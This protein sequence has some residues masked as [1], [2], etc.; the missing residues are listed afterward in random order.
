MADD[1]KQIM[2]EDLDTIVFDTAEG[3]DFAVFTSSTGT[4]VDPC[5][6]MVEHDV[7]VQLEGYESGV[8]TLGTAI[9]AMFSDVGRPKN[10]SVFV[11]AGTERYT[12]KG[13]EECDGITTKMKVVKS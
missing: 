1:L 4:V 9:T 3:A 10:G 12:V 5:K 6:V 7:L 2:V 11:V 8:S 13:I